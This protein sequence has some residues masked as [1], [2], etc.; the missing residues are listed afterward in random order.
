MHKF[1][2]IEIDLFIEAIY[3]AYGYDFRNYS[4]TH[5]TRRVL[6]RLEKDKL[7]SVSELQDRILNEKGYFDEVIKEFSINVTRF[8]R[9][10]DFFISFKE[11]VIPY[12]KSFPKF[13]IWHAGCSTGE[14][15]Y[16]VAI[17][18]EEAGLL[19]R[20]TIYGTDFNSR[21]I[22]QC[23]SGRYDIDAMADFQERYSGIGGCGSIDQYFEIGSEGVII[24][25]HIKAHVSFH[26]HNL[27]VDQ[28]FGEMT[29]ILC[30]NVMIYFNKHLQN[31][32]LQLIDQSLRKGGILCLGAQET[33]DKSDIEDFYEYKDEEN[34][35]YKKSY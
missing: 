8:F 34:K 13:K 22:G 10:S 31:K 3:R 25:P 14:E 21:V 33:I 1:Q 12:L 9:D 23:I 29:V 28:V 32:V 17:L 7:A 19:D 24:K 11:N 20:C 16:S 5:M 6:K 35:I 4:R 2:D 15:V 30:R 27:V 26:Q 18:L